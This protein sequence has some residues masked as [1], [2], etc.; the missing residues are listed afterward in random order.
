M[1]TPEDLD[2]KEPL[3]PFWLHL[4]RQ[5]SVARW[6][7]FNWFSAKTLLMSINDQVA[8]AIES[9]QPGSIV[10]RRRMRWV[11]EQRDRGVRCEIPI[12]LPD[13]KGM[14]LLG[15]P[16]EMDASQYVL[17]R[18]LSLVSAGLREKNRGID[19]VLLM[20]DVVYPAGDINQ[21]ADAVYLPYFG[22]PQPAWAKA[23]QAWLDANPR[24]DY[25]QLAPLRGF[26]VLAMP[27]NHDWYDG[28]NG[29]MYHAC[30]TEPLAE[31]NY[32]EAGLTRRQ[33]LAK[34]SWRSP[35]P[36]ERERVTTLRADAAR[37]GQQPRDPSPEALVL[38]QGVV[39]YS[40]S[41]EH[42]AVSLAN[43][44][45]QS[46]PNL[47]GPYYAVDLGMHP[48]HRVEVS[49]PNGTRFEQ[50]APAV[51][52]LVVDTGITGTIDP[53]Q[54]EWLAD[55]LREPKLPKVVVTGIP[56][57]VN[58]TVHPFPV[59]EPDDMQRAPATANTLQ[60]ILEAGNSVVATVAGDTHNYQRIVVHGQHPGRSA[61]GVSVT[62][63]SSFPEGEQ[64]PSVQ[65]VAGGA[66]AY[67]SR[68]HNIKYDGEKFPVEGKGQAR[69]FTIPRK[70]HELFPSRRRSVL[71]YAER[72]RGKYLVVLLALVVTGLSSL[73]YLV[74]VIGSEWE[75]AMSPEVRVLRL[76]GPVTLESFVKGPWLLIAALI[77]VTLVVLAC[78]GVWQWVS[79]KGDDETGHS[80]G[81]PSV[82]PGGGTESRKSR[83]VPP[84]LFGAALILFVV[85]AVVAFQ[86]DWQVAPAVLVI[87][88]LIEIGLLASAHYLVPLL[89]S[90]PSLRRS[91]ALKVLLVALVVP[92]IW[93]NV[94]NEAGDKEDR[95][96]SGLWLLLAGLAVVA[97]I[98]LIRSGFRYWHR[99]AAQRLRRGE[100]LALGVIPF[101]A[102]VGATFALTIIWPE[103]V[104]RLLYVT[105]AAVADA[106]GDAVRMNSLGTLVLVCLAVLA[107][108]FGWPLWTARRHLEGLWCGIAGLVGLA[109]GLS[110]WFWGRANGLGSSQWLLI[111]AA[112]LLSLALGMLLFLVVAGRGNVVPQDVD[113]ALDAR[114]RRVAKSTPDRQAAEKP[115][116]PEREKKDASLALAMTIAAIPSVDSLAEATEGEF[117][118]N[119]LTFETHPGV[120][121]TELVFRAY[122]LE[123]ESSPTVMPYQLDGLTPRPPGPGPDTYPEQG[124]FLIDEVR[125]TYT[126]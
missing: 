105:N 123:Q 20:S 120:D 1:L 19:T 118:K 125:I 86:Q 73:A 112:A 106:I 12:R 101:A 55:Q 47:P 88:G 79:R 36:P 58:N 54:A 76:P 15:D 108:T 27:G 107:G 2:L 91:L 83:W 42:A 35:T 64:Y 114:D 62:A 63:G 69:G 96:A 75:Q 25:C 11:A 39:P 98:W 51:R 24:I 23:Q 48:R 100:L 32:D 45:A 52:I 90:F 44:P 95:P 13:T 50:A 81:V 22:L 59:S 33:R 6:G 77:G 8:K 29:F 119:I 70:H 99:K 10:D 28:L 9:G 97:G 71:G 66:G 41:L 84:A 68:T 4:L 5:R 16:G 103:E 21:W 93:F 46:M 49:A 65:I 61:S 89:Q 67:M 40:E 17:V 102:V 104:L 121:S 92:I 31:V 113:D 94:G 126:P 53:E 109:G 117:H 60:S 3:K 18:D 37:L 34:Y 115:D 80:A 124:F 122:G 87:F 56:L 78:I 110:E 82:D 14:L 38:T 26:N 57:L 30:G 85:L 116:R 111:P 43:V 74:H 7:N 72:V